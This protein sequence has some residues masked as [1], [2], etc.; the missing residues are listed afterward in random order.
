MP[1][2]APGARPRDIALLVEAYA[3]L[4]TGIGVAVGVACSL[5]LTRMANGLP[6]GVEPGDPLSLMAAIAVVAL[7][8]D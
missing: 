8:Y 4:W 7:R 1:G 6:F 3:G 2:L 5:A